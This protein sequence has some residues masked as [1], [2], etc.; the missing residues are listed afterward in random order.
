M[1]ENYHLLFSILVESL[2]EKIDDKKR[3]FILNHKKRQI[4]MIKK[5]TKL[6]LT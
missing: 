1:L 6:F 4:S 5:I 2:M 3:I